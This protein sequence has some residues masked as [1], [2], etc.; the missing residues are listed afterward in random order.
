M[1][2]ISEMKELET[3]VVTADMVREEAAELMEQKVNQV[4]AVMIRKDAEI[5]TFIAELKLPAI[6]DQASY[7]MVVES[8]KAAKAASDELEEM[9]T[10]L[11]KPILD[12]KKEIDE[13]FKAS[14]TP[15][16]ML[17]QGT[18]RNCIAY[19]QEQERIRAEAQ[20]KADEEARKERERIEAEARA[21]RAKEEAARKAQE[22]AERKAR[23]TT[24]AAERKKLEAE[25]E[26]KRKEAESAAS[27]ADLK[28]SIASTVVAQ[29]VESKISDKGGVSAV[30]NY[31]ITVENKRAF[32]EWVLEKGALE[33]LIVD[34]KLLTK[35]SKAT[36]GIRTWP[37]VKVVKFYD[38]RM[39]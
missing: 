15:L 28:E 24:D 12:G 34:E 8:G 2:E 5:Q 7:D 25:A 35:E 6:K 16:D 14:K 39:R 38:S 30:E 23:E 32:V 36:K 26:K 13:I 4:K 19:Q 9:R 10:A 22:E 37:G 33:Y 20:R 18:K 3:I 17:V 11:T 21:Q 1:S 31:S 29:V 27:K